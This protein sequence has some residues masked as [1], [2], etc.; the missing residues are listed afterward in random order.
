MSI[1]KNKLIGILIKI[2][3]IIFIIL[4]F[5]SIITNNDIINYI[6]LL[7]GIIA[8]SIII[9]CLLYYLF[10]PLNNNKYGK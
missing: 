4:N 1:F 5:I 10:E 9:I 6:A 2:H 8:A 7:M 3:I